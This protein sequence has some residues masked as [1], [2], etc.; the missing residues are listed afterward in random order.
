MDPRILE[1]RHVHDLAP[2]LRRLGRDETVRFLVPSGGDRDLLLDTLAGGRAYFGPRPRIW[3]WTDLYRELAAELDRSGTPVRVRRQIDPP[4]H[5]LI[6]RHLVEA[7]RKERE[8]RLPPGVLRRGFL[9]LL[10]KDLRELLRVPEQDEGS[11]RPRDRHRVGQ[12]ILPR[13]VHD[14]HVDAVRQRLPGPQPRGPADEARRSVKEGGLHD[15][16]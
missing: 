14:Q 10:G 8:D 9:S 6:L 3:Q 13:L 4:D 15:L 12:R 2:E 1:Y 16:R 7:L 11:R 5:F